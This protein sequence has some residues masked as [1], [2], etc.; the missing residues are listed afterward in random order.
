[1]AAKLDW[2]KLNKQKEELEARM[3][4]SGGGGGIKWWK[5]VNGPNRIRILPGWT[6]EG[7]YA[8]QFWREVGQH[9]N[10]N[11][12]VKGPILCPRDT[13]GLEGSCPICAFCDELKNE[14]ADAQAQTL[15]KNLRAKRAFFLNI[16]DVKNPRYTAEDVAEWKKNRPD[17]E[18]PFEIGAM[19]IQTWACQPTIMDQIFAVMKTNELDI[20][21]LEEGKDIQI[22]K[23]PNKDPMKTRYEVVLIIKSAAVALGTADK[24]P[25]LSLVGQERPYDELKKLLSDGVGGDYTADR[26]A[27]PATAGKKTSTTTK[28]GSKTA[29]KAEEEDEKLPAGWGGAEKEDDA[30]DLMAD[31]ENAMGAD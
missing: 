2:S 24:L 7:A 9:W 15:R 27:L 4:R 17:Q 6:D 21:D 18:V 1:M 31:M 29:P 26:K 30:E 16:V 22:T 20:T 8:G 13:P 23:F 12:D 5:P 28:A 19:K 10:V 14:K 25:D 3:A 11:E